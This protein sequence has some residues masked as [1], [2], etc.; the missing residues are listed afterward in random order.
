MIKVELQATNF[1]NFSC[2]TI[3][4]IQNNP[5]RSTRHHSEEFG[6]PLPGIH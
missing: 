6:K 5:L 4:K 3:G 1:K 2:I